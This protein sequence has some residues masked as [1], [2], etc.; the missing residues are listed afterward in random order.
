MDL[1]RSTLTEIKALLDIASPSESSAPDAR[2]LNQAKASLPG[3]Y[4]RLQL[5]EHKMKELK[6]T[7]KK[8]PLSS[9]MPSG[10]TK[11]SIQAAKL[12]L[13]GRDST[14]AET[15]LVTRFNLRGELVEDRIMPNP[16]A[17]V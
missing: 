3:A 7:A 4:Q 6:E 5:L 13:S 15:G 8:G 14:A 11:R 17:T 10:S 16:A 1:C 9:A 2:L 12:A